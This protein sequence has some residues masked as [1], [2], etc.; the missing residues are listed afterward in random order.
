MRYCPNK[1]CPLKICRQEDDT[2]P[3]MTPSQLI[4]AL[5][6]TF[7]VAEICGVSAPSVSA[8]RLR[9]MP[10]ARLQ[11]FQATRPDIFDVDDFEKGVNAL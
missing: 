3:V 9:G 5:G 1:T 11:F 10:K 8:W 2:L 6:G 4:D 7:K